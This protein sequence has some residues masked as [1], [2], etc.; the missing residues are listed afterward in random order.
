MCFSAAPVPFGDANENLERYNIIWTKSQFS[1]E[2]VLVHNKTDGHGVESSQKNFN[3]LS[4]L[5]CSE[6]LYTKEVAEGRLQQ[7]H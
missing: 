1:L 2:T 6:L 4:F 3:F 7:Q 5:Y